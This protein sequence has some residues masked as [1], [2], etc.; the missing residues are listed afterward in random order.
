MLNLPNYCAHQR[1]PPGLLLPPPRPICSG[2]ALFVRRVDALNS[3]VMRSNGAPVTERELL[4]VAV[5]FKTTN[6]QSST[7]TI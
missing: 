6:D 2:V 5:D 1:S 4:F 7:E 3:Y